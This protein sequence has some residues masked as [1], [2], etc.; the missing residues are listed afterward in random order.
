MPKFNK[1]LFRGLDSLKAEQTEEPTLK[2]GA[3]LLNDKSK[4]DLKISYLNRDDIEKNEMSYMDFVKKYEGESIE[5]YLKSILSHMEKEIEN[6]L[7][8]E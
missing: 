1:E 5:D 4:N 3:G 7:V 8:R 2:V 6:G